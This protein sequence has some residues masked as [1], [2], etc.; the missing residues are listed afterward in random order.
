VTSDTPTILITGANGFL[1]SRLC[2]TF[3]SRGFA[4]I[5]GVRKTADLTLLDGV[6]VSY[7]YGDITDA[8][9]LAEMVTGCDYVIHNAGI[10]K[11][12]TR[13][14]FFAVNAGGT[15][16]ICEAIIKSGG[17]PKR[18]VQISSLAV[19]GPSL[20]KPVRESDSPN[21]ITTY[22]HSKLE[23]ERI[24]LEYSK[25]FPVTVVRPAGIYGPGD[26][27]LFSFFQAGARGLRV[28]LGNSSRKIQIVHVDDVCDATY[29][30]TT[31]E[32]AS[33][34]IFHVAEQTAYRMEELVDMVASAC[35]KRGIPLAIPGWIL[36]GA[37]AVSETIYRMA[38]RVPMLTKE[39]AGELLASWEVS[40]DKARDVLGFESHIPFPI[41][42]SGTY[43]WYVAHGWL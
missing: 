19:S 30:A 9:S 4:V 7:R 13:E 5:A 2:R 16:A 40:I 25:Q 15:R 27:E 41:G 14:A 11:A 38:G 21:P 10:V 1:G 37:G 34:E 17:S 12:R 22:G 29:L 43:D 35:G 6:T 20:G 8:D 39:K 32:V 36:H 31:K 26:R 42:A 18:F 33:G 24:A 28:Y 3:A 23:G